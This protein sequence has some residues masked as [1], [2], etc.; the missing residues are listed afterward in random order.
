MLRRDSRIVRIDT[1]G[2]PVGKTCKFS[3]ASLT[4]GRRGFLH[5]DESTLAHFLPLSVTEVATTLRPPSHDAFINF[6][7]HVTE[8]R[9]PRYALLCLVWLDLDSAHYKL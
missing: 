3:I 2:F 1:F 5:R 6:T 9:S 8:E 4:L 7:D